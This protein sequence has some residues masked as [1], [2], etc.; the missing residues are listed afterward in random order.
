MWD[1]SQQGHEEAKISSDYPLIEFARSLVTYLPTYTESSPIT[2]Q[3]VF[4][5]FI[6]WLK[7][8]I[9]TVLSSD[10]RRV[11]RISILICVFYNI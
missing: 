2:P 4:S 5:P 6:K 1:R 10:P 9:S 11:V 3:W 8:V 7:N